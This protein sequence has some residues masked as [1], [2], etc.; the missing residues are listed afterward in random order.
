MQTAVTK[1]SPITLYL[2]MSYNPWLSSSSSHQ[3]TSASSMSAPATSTARG[4]NVRPIKNIVRLL[5]GNDKGNPWIF[6][7]FLVYGIV[8]LLPGLYIYIIP[9]NSIK[10]WVRYSH[11]KFRDHSFRAA[12][13]PI[14]SM[15]G[16]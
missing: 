3:S 7:V 13:T 6:Q 11:L 1:V 10:K 12:F 2:L 8:A 9:G 4:M 14:K 16:C 5:I 15:S